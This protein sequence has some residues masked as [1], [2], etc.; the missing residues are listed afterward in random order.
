MVFAWV[1]PQGCQVCKEIP[2]AGVG[3][4]IIVDSARWA[5]TSF[6]NKPGK[7]VLAH[8]EVSNTLD[9]LQNELTEVAIDDALVA[10]EDLNVLDAHE[11]MSSC[12]G[13][14]Y[15]MARSGV[16]DSVI[17]SHSSDDLTLIVLQVT[18]DMTAM[19]VADTCIKC[20]DSALKV[21][22]ET[23]QQ[24][25]YRVWRCI[26]T[27]FRCSRVVRISLPME[28]ADK[29]NSIEDV[30]GMVIGYQGALITYQKEM[31]KMVMRRWKYTYFAARNEQTYQAL[32]KRARVAPQAPAQLWLPIAIFQDYMMIADVF[33]AVCKL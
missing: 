17:H 24:A 7:P 30:R 15:G 31:A 27:M 22:T 29:V 1:S 21:T 33:S 6:H 23:V 2:V 5:K 8:C 11:H 16:T 9:G 3:D 26:T 13:I 18:T 19:L 25:N 4:V 20:L 14:F 28:L 32:C 10:I 12:A